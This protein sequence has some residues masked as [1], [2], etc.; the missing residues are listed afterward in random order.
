V[1]NLKPERLQVLLD[2]IEVLPAANQIELHPYSSQ[3]ATRDFDAAHGILTQAWSPIGGS[4]ST[5][6]TLGRA[7]STTRSSSAS[8][9]RTANP[10][11]R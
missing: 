5:G 6:A 8:A 2:R 7:R 10:P 11:R 9:R 3:Q 1:S 4:P